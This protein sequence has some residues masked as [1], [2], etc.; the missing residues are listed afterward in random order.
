VLLEGVIMRTE[1]PKILLVDDTPANLFATQ[2]VLKELNC[3]TITA[4]SGQEALDMLQEY[5]FALVLMD[6]HMPIMDG[7]EAAKRIFDNPSTKE[8]PIIF[9]TADKTQTEVNKLMNTRAVGYMC[10][11]IDTDALK[12]KV[13]LF[14]NIYDQK[15]RLKK[16]K[17]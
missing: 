1:K 14:L 16:R 13:K 15:Q 5:E 9:V 7:F 12:R 3:Q 10:K 2:I 4:Q 17:I 6:I 11:P 8:T